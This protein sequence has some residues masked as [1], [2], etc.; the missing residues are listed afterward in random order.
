VLTVLVADGNPLLRLG[1]RALLE[2]DPEMSIVGEAPDGAQ[3]IALT[4]RH[5][6]DVVLLDA[7]IPGIGSVA[8]TAQIAAL[9]RVVLLAPSVEPSI[10]I[11]AVAAGARGF[12]VHGQFDQW[13]LADVIRGIAEGMSYLS[14]PAAA[15]LVDRCHQ[16]RRVASGSANLTRREHEIMELI[17]GGLS[18][19]DIAQRLVISEKTVKNH[20][21]NIYQRLGA[22][23]REHSVALWRSLV[24]ND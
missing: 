11:E 3:T 14:P 22:G 6:P 2:A 19:R 1:I 13:Q 20:V 23:G 18:N 9:T 5:N 17:A 21:H 10:V 12:L 16:P 8:T 24:R 4:R 15:A 7:A